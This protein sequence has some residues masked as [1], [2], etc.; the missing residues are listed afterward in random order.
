M[1]PDF[2]RPVSL[3]RTGESEKVAHG[4]FIS[5]VWLEIGI[6]MLALSATA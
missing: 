6:S 4:H 5:M 1:H 2:N 3:D